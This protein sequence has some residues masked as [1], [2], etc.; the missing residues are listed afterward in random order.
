MAQMDRLRLNY[1]LHRYYTNAATREEM[2]EVMTFILA[3]N[4]DPALMDELFK[5][6]ESGDIMQHL[7]QK[8]SYEDKFT[9]LMEQARQLHK[10]RKSARRIIYLTGIAAAA[11]LLFVMVG[12][13]FFKAG[14]QKDNYTTAIAKPLENDITP[15]TN[16]AILTLADNSTV[17]LDSVH[18]GQLVQQGNTNITK[19]DSIQLVYNNID[20]KPGVVLYNTLT[21]P[22]GGQHQLVL[23][24]GT[25][26]WLNAASSLRFPTSFQGRNRVVELTGE[27]YFEV[28]KDAARPFQVKIKN[29]VV[30]V[31]GTHFNV[32]AYEDESNITTTLLEGAVKITKGSESKLLKPGQQ[33]VV[34]LN[35]ISV[36]T[37][38]IKTEQ[39]V[40][41]KDNNFS[42]ANSAV[43]PIMRQ[44]ARWYDVDISYGGKVSDH[45]TGT[46]PRNVNVS[47]VFWSL[48]QTGSVHFRIEGRKI[49][50]MP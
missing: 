13:Y 3:S 38:Q 8:V 7:Q 18:T 39:A 24:D 10:E 43:E 20:E 50:V 48:Q 4:D 40:A 25:R 37:D 28:T 35:G 16:K 46:I 23:A 27:A 26:V 11:V 22:K 17:V 19:L 1:L 33:A 34:E 31:L 14:K 42:F 32:N 47:K 44:L 49:I 2:E 5:V 21:I 6:W 15:G 12:V 36:T 9:G 29:T 41:W 45:F 30:E